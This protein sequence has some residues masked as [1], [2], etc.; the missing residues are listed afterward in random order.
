MLSASG[1]R[2]I[3]AE[4]EGG[5]GGLE[6][7]IIGRWWIGARILDSIGAQFSYSHRRCSNIA[8]GTSMVTL[9]VTGVIGLIKKKDTTWMPDMI[10]SAM[11]TT[12]AMLDN[13]G[14]TC[15]N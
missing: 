8:W 1:T 12:A 15:W 13:R 3:R 4:A 7:S 9:H 2:A 6:L 11:M 14:K 5:G 10:R